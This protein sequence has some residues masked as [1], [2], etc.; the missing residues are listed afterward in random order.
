MENGISG[1]KVELQDLGQRGEIHQQD[2]E[3]VGQTVWKR[4]NKTCD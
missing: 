1:E 3:E 2:A 4:G